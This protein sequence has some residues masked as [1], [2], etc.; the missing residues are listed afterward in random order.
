MSAAFCLLITAGVSIGL[1]FIVYVCFDSSGSSKTL[2]SSGVRWVILILSTL[3]G[4]IVGY[5][6]AK[7]R[8]L[9]LAVLAMFGGIGIGYI[10]T[11][12]TLISSTWAYYTILGIS[13]LLIGVLTY[14][15]Q[16]TLVIIMTSFIGSYFMLRGVA[17]LVNNDTF[18]NEATLHDM[19]M[20]CSGITKKR[21][22]SKCYSWETFPKEYYY[23]MVA[24][25]IMTIASSYGQFKRA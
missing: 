9:G 23:Y 17:F 5:F 16:N 8:S 4:F 25:I 24:I 14:F 1:Q 6:C 18:P 7:M 10:I 11:T 3:I 20:K 21:D 22:A 19:L 15:L 13:C 2:D 12:A